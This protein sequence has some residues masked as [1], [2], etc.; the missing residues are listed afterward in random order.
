M[1]QC[2][3]AH[4]ISGVRLHLEVARSSHFGHHGTLWSFMTSWYTNKHTG[5]HSGHGHPS[6]G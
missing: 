4:G 2:F 3:K 1:R 5:G 6:I